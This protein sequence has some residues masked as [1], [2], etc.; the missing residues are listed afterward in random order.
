MFDSL[1]VVEAIRTIAFHELVDHSS[2]RIAQ[3]GVAVDHFLQDFR[4]DHPD[5]V[6]TTKPGVGLLGEFG[7]HPVS[8]FELASHLVGTRHKAMVALE[9]M[10]GGMPI[11]MAYLMVVSVRST[12][13][14][15]IGLNHALRYAV[16]ESRIANTVRVR[17]L[18]EE[19]KKLDADAA[20]GK[21]FKVNR[22]V[23]RLGPVATK[24]KAHMAKHPASKA[25]DVWNALKKSPPKGHDF[26]ESSGLG[27]Y[28]EKGPETVM[29]WRRFSNLVSQHRPKK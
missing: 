3:I 2:D 10:A 22:K 18:C 26:R 17:G 8:D 20:H 1:D 4:R 11:L 6:P 29:E 12:P 9:R 25:I 24:I 15:G 16:S 14:R 13:L 7:P 5:K 23:G 21:L 28:I 19:I 27:R